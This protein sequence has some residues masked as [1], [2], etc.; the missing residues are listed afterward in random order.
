MQETVTACLP[1]F[2]INSIL[3]LIIQVEGRVVQRK[4]SYGLG[5]QVNSTV[6]VQRSDK[7]SV[8]VPVVGGL[9]LV[10]VSTEAKG[11][12]LNRNFAGVD[13]IVVNRNILVGQT[14]FIQ[15]A[16]AGE[17]EIVAAT[18]INFSFH[19]PAYGVCS[20]NAVID[21][22]GAAARGVKINHMI[23]C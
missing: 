20:F 6:F 7:A 22:P 17:S 8:P 10:L 14:V 4:R 15:H 2:Q 21:N 18:V 16:V 1:A 19:I 23:D 12:S 9:V 11:G 13:N 5:I 3:I